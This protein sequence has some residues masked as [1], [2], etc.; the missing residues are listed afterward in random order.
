MSLIPS[1]ESWDRNSGSKLLDLVLLLSLDF[2]PGCSRELP[3][4]FSPGCSP[5]FPPSNSLS[6]QRRALLG[7]DDWL[8]D[9]LA[10]YS[11]ALANFT[12][13]YAVTSSVALNWRFHGARSKSPLY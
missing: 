6:D 5:G 8:R 12:G 11:Q 4:L 7:I 10:H 9:V 13:Y 2:S 3:I 1:Q